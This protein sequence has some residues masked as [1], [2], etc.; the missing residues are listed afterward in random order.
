ML[1]FLLLGLAVLLTA[2]LAYVATRPADFRITRSATLTAPPEVIFAEVNDFRRWEAWSPWSQMEPE[3]SYRYSGPESGT[4]ASVHWIGRKTGEGINTILEST[5]AE[6][7]RFRLQFLKPFEA[8]NAADFAFRPVG[9][10]T[11]V[12]WT[13]TGRNGFLGK[14]FGLL[15]NCE[16]MVGGQFEQGLENLRR[17][18]ERGAPAAAR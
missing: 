17:L 9:D 1:P 14:L 15:L 11:V 3:A 10:G 6:R 18:T 4:G 8:T 12:T 5:P 16:K 2:F 7:I 13:M